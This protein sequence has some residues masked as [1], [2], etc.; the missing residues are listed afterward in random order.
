MPL[1]SSTGGQDPPLDM[2]KVQFSQSL[3]GPNHYD[4]TLLC[5][6]HALAKTSISFLH[7]VTQTIVPETSVP[8]TPNQHN[9]VEAPEIA[10]TA[11]S[12][13][14]WKTYTAE[15]AGSSSRRLGGD[16]YPQLLLL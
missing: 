12:V 9:R 16:N 2:D 4:T 11:N 8:A 5:S 7:C 15:L 10:F 14:R 1:S 6:A 13:P 3:P